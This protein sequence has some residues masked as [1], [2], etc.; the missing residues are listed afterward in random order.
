MGSEREVEMTQ[1]ELDELLK[2]LPT[3]L[4]EFEKY[5]VANTIKIPFLKT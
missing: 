2:D 3:I 4:K 1:E 5:D